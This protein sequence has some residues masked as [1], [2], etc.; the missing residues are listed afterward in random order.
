MR[1]K[2]HVARRFALIQSQL[3]FEPLPGLVNEGDH[4]DGDPA[5]IGCKP[6]DVVVGL[7]LAGVQDVVVAEGGEAFVPPAGMETLLPD[8]A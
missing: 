8:T 5:K 3:G 4:R 1:T 2:R 6:G 7:F